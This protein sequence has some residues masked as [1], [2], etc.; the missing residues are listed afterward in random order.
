[1]NKLEEILAI[2]PFKLTPSTSF[3]GDLYFLSKTEFEK[4]RKHIS[5]SDYS[6]SENEYDT[7]II[8]NMIFKY[9]ISVQREGLIDEILESC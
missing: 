8:A 7:I 4:L 3:K 9:D 5:I 2:D 1:M 6:M